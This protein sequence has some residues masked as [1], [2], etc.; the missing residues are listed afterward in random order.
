MYWVPG[1]TRWTGTAPGILYVATVMWLRSGDTGSGI[2]NLLNRLAS[3]VAVNSMDFVYSDH[4]VPKYRSTVATFSYILLKANPEHGIDQQNY[5]P[6]RPNG[7]LNRKSTLRVP[8]Y[9]FKF[10]PSP[11]TSSTLTIS[12]IKYQGGEKE[13]RYKI[14][15]SI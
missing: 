13:K 15:I 14:E 11:S 8:N 7:T 2:G 10:Q 12:N 5:W 9:L 3:G 4:S 1:C 6:S